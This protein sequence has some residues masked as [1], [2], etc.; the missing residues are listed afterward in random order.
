MWWNVKGV[1]GSEEIKALNTSLPIPRE[2]MGAGWKAE[3]GLQ[4]LL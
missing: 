1:F 2:L 3:E 4:R